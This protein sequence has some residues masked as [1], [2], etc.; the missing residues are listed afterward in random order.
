VTLIAIGSVRGA[1]GVTTLTVALAAVWDRVGAEPLVVEADPDGGVLAARF[2]LG[3]Q[4][5]LTQLGARARATLDDSAVWD[6]AQLLPGGL[7]VVVAHPAADQG[8]ATLRTAG[9]RIAEHLAALPGHDVLVDVG[10]VRPGSPASPI[11]DRAALVLVVLRPRVDEV[12]AAV[13]R[14]AAVAEH[15]NVGI[16]VVGGRRRD[17]EDVEGALGLPVLGVIAHD[18]RGAGTLA[19]TL[20]ARGLQRLPL[21]R[22]ARELARTL[23]S[24]LDMAV[25]A[26]AQRAAS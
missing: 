4:P 13:H 7:P 12:D 23:A 14:L 19:S 2:S 25:R 10:R 1:P 8:H 6:A 3:H 15:G 17:A 11:I 24:H 20:T 26:D 5:S 18:T 9:G 22:T 16:V 21:L